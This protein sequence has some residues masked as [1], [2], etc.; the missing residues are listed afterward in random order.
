VW[1]GVGVAVSSLS[2]YPYLS[3]YA[4]LCLFPYSV[5]DLRAC[6]C[7]RMFL[8]DTQIKR[9]LTPLLFL[10]SF[11]RKRKKKKKKKGGGG[12]GVF[13]KNT[14]IK[15]NINPRLFFIGFGR[16]K[17]KKKKKKCVGGCCSHNTKDYVRR[18]LAR[19]NNFFIDAQKHRQVFFFFFFSPH[20]KSRVH[21]IIIYQSHGES[22][23]FI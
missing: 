13:L 16:K 23:R 20:S 11:V 1:D 21:H 17:K 15:K 10:M 19:S 22:N 7:V 4:Y 9:N 18:S 5:C 2:C 8:K 14:K 3:I 6:V 12:G